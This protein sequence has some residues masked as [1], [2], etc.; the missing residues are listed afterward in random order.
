MEGGQ[1]P[2]ELSIHEALELAVGM[3]K[4]GIWEAA[5][6]IYEHVLAAVPDQVD[7]QHFL[8]LCR[9]QRGL[10]EEGIERVSRAL[11]LAP[12]HVE[13]R[14]NLG[15][16]CLERGRLDEAEAAYRRVLAAH[17]DHTAALTNLG[18]V[19]RRRDDGPGAE[20]AF[21]RALELDPGHGEAHH[22]LGSLLRDTG[23]P[24]EALTQFQR[25]LML[26][27][28]DGESYR[29]VGLILS[30]LGRREEAEEIYRSWLKLEPQ[31]PLAQHYLAACTG[32]GVPRRASDIYVQRTFDGFAASFDVVLAR[33][34][35][36]APALVAQTVAALRGAPGADLDVLDA[37]AGSGLCAEGLRPYARRLVGVDLSP[38]ML[39]KARERG[40]YDALDVGELTAYMSERPGAFDLVASA[41][42]FVYLGELVTPIAAAARTLRPGGHLVFTLERE[43]EAPPG[44]FRLNHHGRYGHGEA[45]VRRVLV[46]AGLEIVAIERVHL[47]LEA[48]RPVEGMLVS[49]AKAS[50]GGP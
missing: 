28:Y 27:P 23:R 35:Y 8:G 29:R 16:M 17:P 25:A 7:A 40:G 47:R 3:H 4:A 46:E 38:G 32:V 20:A 30:A 45:Y 49:A 36:R 5:E 1:N 41:D 19:L 34:Q 22:N 12:E 21:R 9:Y 26:R 33:L 6:E 31:S 48:Q 18:I 44:G 14:N 24:E 13:A 2:A 39:A 15:N 11:A 42:T 50:R 37:G 43:D 10:H